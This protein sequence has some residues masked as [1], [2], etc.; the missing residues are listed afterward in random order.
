MDDRYYIAVGTEQKGP[1]TFSQ[2]QNMWRSG[3]ITADA[4]YCQQGFDEWV[5]I[6]SLVQ[7]LEGQPAAVALP[8]QHPALARMESDKRIL[9]ALI[10]CFFLGIIGAHA[11]YAG[12][13][14]QGVSFLALPVS[15]VLIG[16]MFSGSN[17]TGLASFFPPLA[18][19]CV[20]VF[21]FGDLI[22]ILVGAYK[23]GQGRKITRWT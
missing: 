9:P 3:A 15:A 10:L 18:V 1:Y 16:I 12:R 11:F 13:L 2:L 7:L 17:G 22:R 4:L 8:A 5:P 21:A 19:I 6:S 14:R 20:V 23:D